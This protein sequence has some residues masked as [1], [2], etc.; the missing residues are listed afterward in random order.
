[1]NFEKYTFL[2]TQDSYIYIYDKW[3]HKHG[4]YLKRNGNK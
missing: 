4:Q 3:F 1:M 2:S